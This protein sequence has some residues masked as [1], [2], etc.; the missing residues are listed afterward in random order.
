MTWVGRINIK[1]LVLPRAIYRFNV[2]FLPSNAK[3]IFLKSRRKNY[4]ELIWK[5]ETP[6]TA[7]AILNKNKAKQTKTGSTTIPDFKTY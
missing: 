2:I 3:D 5:H 4:P 6:L 7:K 1:M